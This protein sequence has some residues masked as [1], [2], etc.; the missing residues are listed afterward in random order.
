MKRLHYFTLWEDKKEDK[1]GQ[2]NKPSKKQND[3]P[4]S[5]ADSVVSLFSKDMGKT[6]ITVDSI[7][8]YNFIMASDKR[9][10]WLLEGMDCH[11]IGMGSPF[12]REDYV[13]FLNTLQDYA[14]TMLAE[15]MEHYGFKQSP[16]SFMFGINGTLR[17]FHTN[18]QDLYYIAYPNDRVQYDMVSDLN[19]QTVNDKFKAT[20]EKTIGGKM[21]GWIRKKIE[22]LQNG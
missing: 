9:E 8:G 10:L 18:N 7:P 6:P 14:V 12:G 4:N 15:R 11:L 20:V 21:V 19:D 5:P 17:V 13:D 3:I 2:E 22:Q 1:K 16:D